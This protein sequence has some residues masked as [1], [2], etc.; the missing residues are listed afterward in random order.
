MA[1]AG[2]VP[3]ATFLFAQV[4]AV[5]HTL[6]PNHPHR[7]AITSPAAGQHIGAWLAGRGRWAMGWAD[8]GHTVVP[9]AV[10]TFVLP[11][12]TAGEG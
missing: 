2:T 10:C 11:H 3:G 8:A 12:V 5:D 9:S 6:N 1:L 4:R 7:D